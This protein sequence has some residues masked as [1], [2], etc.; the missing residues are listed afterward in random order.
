[1]WKVTLKRGNTQYRRKI[2]NDT[3]LNV[4]LAPGRFWERVLDGRLNDLVAQK[5]AGSSSVRPDDTD[6]VVTATGRS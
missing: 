1:M 2:S 5:F 3:E 4:A 6:V